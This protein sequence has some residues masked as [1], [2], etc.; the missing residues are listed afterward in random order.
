MGTQAQQEAAPATRNDRPTL[1][2]IGRGE[3]MSE[4]VRTQLERKRIAMETA[5]AERAVEAVVAAAPDLVVL[6][7]DA[8]ADEGRAVLQALAAHAVASVVPV[9]LL[10]DHPTLDRR[11]RAFRSGAVAV[12][13]RSASAYEI[14][15]RVAEL[16]RELPERPGEAAG[17]LGEATMD[18]L[19]DLVSQEL[20]SGILSVERS[21]GD[22]VRLVLGAGGPV[23]ELLEDFV[24]RLKPLIE[25]AEPL[26]YELYETSGGRLR[27][28][29]P[30]DHPRGDLALLQGLRL[31]LM[32]DDPGRADG[33]AQ[34][35][36]ARGALVG[37]T[38]VSVRGLERAR[39][40]D[41]AV[42]VLD[43]G[44]IEGEG[45]EAVRRIR[46]DPRLRWAGLL[47]ARWEELWPSGEASPDLEEL[48][49]RLAP[50]VEHD[51]AL[52]QR[53][54]TEERFDTRLELTG[55]SRMLR[56]LAGS[57]SGGGPA[58]TRHLTVR[59]PDVTVEVDLSEGL[60]VG[61]TAARQAGSVEG[62][63]ALATLM[64]LNG[65]RVHVEKREH[66]ATATVMLP[67]DEALD[68]AA[69]QLPATPTSHPP[70]PLVPEGRTPSGGFPSVSELASGTV[71]VD[72]DPS[73]T[74]PILAPHLL[75]S[76]RHA[77]S[78]EPSAA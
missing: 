56:C 77:A 69:K 27:L 52:A 20:R 45:F 49:G 73:T 17:E 40:L 36:R 4:A 55:P 70:P 35:L 25:K 13:P 2:W 14:A 43:A 38:K 44:A 6:A 59:A 65:G 24:Q 37:V 12:V 71:E 21:G 48:A 39:G 61:A 54:A 62:T 58:G 57:I 66:P 26:R 29:D 53:A 67:V 1:L 68:A 18:E 7:G 8:A 74:G 78:S 22:S 72:D 42:I 5:D 75:A 46:R 60:I 30:E 15:E 10:L 76:S 33:L 11:L 63:A 34:A 16:A 32:D 47:L 41:P 64:G 31:L 51:R 28:L 3:A 50:L 9:A 19:V 23:A